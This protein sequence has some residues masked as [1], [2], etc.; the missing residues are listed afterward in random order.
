MLQGALYCQI[1]AL[2]DGQHTTDEIVAALQPQGSLP[3]LYY[4]LMQLE[5][6]G[7]TIESNSTRLDFV[8]F[9]GFS[10]QRVSV[11][12]YI[13]AESQPTLE[14]LGQASATQ[15]TAALRDW[16]LTPVP[17]DDPDVD[18][19]IVLTDN[20]LHPNLERYNQ[21]TL[22]AQRPWLIVKPWGEQIW[23]GPW[24]Q[25]DDTGCWG[26]LAQRLRGN[27]PVDAW[28]SQL[29]TVELLQTEVWGEDPGMGA[30]ALGLIRQALYHSETVWGQLLTFNPR[31]L[32][33]RSHPLPHRP[34]C[35][36]CGS[37][38]FQ[39]ICTDQ[40]PT[41]PWVLSASPKAFTQDGGH[42]SQPP[43]IT[44]EQL[45][46]H[47]SPLLGIIRELR[48]VPPAHPNHTTQTLLHTYVAGHDTGAT[49]ETLNALK[50]N[51]QGRS[52]GKGK[53]AIQAQVS[54]L[55]EA[56]ERH[57]GI[58]QGYELHRRDRYNHLGPNLAIDPQPLLLFSPSQ[59]AN[60]QA[61]NATLPNLRHQV[62]EPFDPEAEVD[63]TP[64]WSLTE[65]RWKYIPT[66]YCYYNYPGNKLN[67]PPPFCYA[68][69]NG[70]AA[71][72]SREEAILQGL[73]ELVERD[74]VAIWWCNQ[75]GRPEVDLTSFP[76][77]YFTQLQHHYAEE[78]GRTLYVLDLTHD[79]GIPT[80]AAVSYLLEPIP[81][82]EGNNPGIL[83]G[84]GCHF[85]GA[86]ALSRA[87][88]EINQ[89]LVGTPVAK[90]RTEDGGEKN[91]T[92]GETPLQL[93]GQDQLLPDPSQPRR[94]YEDFSEEWRQ[95][96]RD[97]VLAGMEILRSH[98]LEMLVLDQTRP[99]V[100]LPVVRVVVP[101]MRHFWHR[102]APG[103]LY[104][105]PV[106]MGWLSQ[107]KT[108]ADVNPILF[109]F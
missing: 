77:P 9:A 101:K 47:I 57:S 90:A 2:I 67:Q 1:A 78:Q 106:E 28:L 25:P 61:W 109:P 45:Q 48:E 33:S 27:R 76:D 19:G 62:P 32:T 104:E 4:A 3:Q 55:C 95:D 86:I 94:R 63:W 71:G 6:K 15:L 68:N 23:L 93:E 14:A 42:R 35:L 43:E 70:C 34:Q 97:D 44:L 22:A 21:L 75:L 29:E 105:V 26:C 66:A 37:I 8:S 31:T 100:N 92:P 60:R 74:A 11:K 99:D 103:R 51:L 52:A 98:G 41:E 10:V 73:F 50:I 30:I 12:T 39:T 56:I 18:L 65:N 69:S 88:T 81:T 72:N 53:T 82:G 59:Y 89:L 108:E 87:L 46:P 17:P 13:S 64:I 40:L 102:L 36:A 91:E 80:F 20:Y 38:D 85:D 79:L 7:Y 24:F 84:F 58:F 54:A 96:L 16:G 83:C 49:P 5:E 107:P